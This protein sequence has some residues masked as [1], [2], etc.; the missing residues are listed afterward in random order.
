V[1]RGAS[2][3]KFAALA[4][5]FVYLV[6]GLVGFAVTGFDGLVANQ[7]EALLGFD[8]N[9]FHNIVHLGIGVGLIGVSLAPESAVAEGALIGGGVVYLLAAFLGFVDHLQILSIDDPL[10]PDNFLHLASGAAALLLGVLGALQTR[11][12]LRAQA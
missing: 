3:A 6:I 7:G 1:A 8:L 12:R 10:A 11:A 9:P 5:G 2:I 4:V